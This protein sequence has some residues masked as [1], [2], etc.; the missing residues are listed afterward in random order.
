MNNIMMTL[1]EATAGFS[2]VTIIIIIAVATAVSIIVKLATS[3]KKNDCCCKE[4]TD[5]TSTTSADTKT[6]MCNEEIA[7]STALY[8]YLNEMHIEESGVITIEPKNSRYSPW[9][10]KIYG[11]NNVGF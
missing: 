10:S 4:N 6:C 8:M 5:T 9:N 1:G 7:I 2:I 11:L 3:K